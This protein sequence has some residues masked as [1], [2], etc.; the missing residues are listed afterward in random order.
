MVPK[1]VADEQLIASN[2]VTFGVSSDIE[3]GHKF[4]AGDGEKEVTFAMYI[5]NLKGEK[6]VESEK[7]YTIKFNVID[8]ICTTYTIVSD[9]SGSTA[10]STASARQNVVVNVP[11]KL[12]LDNFSF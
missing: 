8:D 3:I 2:K 1:S 6:M 5:L 9:S 10:G 4:A 11:F 7:L 12:L